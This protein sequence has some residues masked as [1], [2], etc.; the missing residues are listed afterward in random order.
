MSFVI[1]ARTGRPYEHGSAILNQIG[2]AAHFGRGRAD[3]MDRFRADSDRSFLSGLP[4]ARKDALAGAAGGFPRDFE[5]IYEEILQEERRPLNY[6]LLWRMDT[7]VP[8]GAR[9]YT[10]RRRLGQG[11]AVYY[12]GGGQEIPKVSGSYVEET[13]KVGYIVSAVETNYFDAISNDFARRNEFADQSRDAIRFIEE[14]INRT[15]FFGEK[16]AGIYGFLDYPSLAKKVST[17][18]FSSDAGSPQAILD[19]LNETVNF[20]REASGGTF[21][22]TRLAMPIKERN[23]LFQRRFSDSSDKSIGEYFLDSQS[24]AGGGIREINE[25]HE[26]TGAGPGGASAVIAYDD[27]LESTAFT[28]VQAPTAMPAHTLNSFTS[29][30]VYMAAVGGMAMRNVGNNVVSFHPAA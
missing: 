30:V 19:A 12:R 16:A 25:A 18:P 26:L 28:L 17:V 24:K 15:A 27:S 1:D 2:L 7:R 11:E 20:A 23:Y 13:F 9:T 29:Q 21:R 6:K 3:S 10:V 14:R 8:L 4:Q 22:P 5:H